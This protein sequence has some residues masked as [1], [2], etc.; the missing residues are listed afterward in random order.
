M[1][2]Y[3]RLCILLGIAAIVTGSLGCTSRHM[4]ASSVAPAPVPEV[5]Y[6]TVR[7]TL[8]PTVVELPGIVTAVRSVTLRAPVAGEVQTVAEDGSRLPAGGVAALLAANG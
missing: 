1:N 3:I 8:S 2:K 6:T 7:A 5:L 4:E